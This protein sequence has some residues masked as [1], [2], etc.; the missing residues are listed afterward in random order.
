MQN[1]LE[2]SFGLLDLSSIVKRFML[3]R[4]SGVRSEKYSL[5]TAI[6]TIYF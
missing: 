4:D 5:N 3:N 1:L 6:L 2:S